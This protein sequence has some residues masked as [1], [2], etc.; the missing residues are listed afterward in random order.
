ML[1]NL[2]VDS[3]LSNPRVRFEK[4]KIFS[5]T[6]IL[7]FNLCKDEK[8]ALQDLKSNSNITFLSAD[9]GNATV[10]LNMPEYVNKI[11]N[12]IE[13]GSDA[14]T[15]R[16]PSY[17]IKRELSVLLKVGNLLENASKQLISK[18]FKLSRLIWSSKNSQRDLSL[19]HITKPTRLAMNS[20]TVY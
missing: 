12:L 9:K 15:S 2:V 18:N 1:L 14:P 11:N 17:K 10:K 13:D 8:P 6:K 4:A 5:K 20:K 16:N 19:I 3:F 7:K